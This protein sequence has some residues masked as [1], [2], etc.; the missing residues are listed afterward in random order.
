MPF[1]N[2]AFFICEMLSIVY[3][4]H[5]V[6]IV[7]YLNQWWQFYKIDFPRDRILATKRPL[8]MWYDGQQSTSHCCHLCILCCYSF[9]VVIWSRQ[10]YYWKSEFWL[11][12]ILFYHVLLGHVP[13]PKQSYQE[14]LGLNKVINT[15][16]LYFKNI[17]NIHIN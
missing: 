12:K 17:C 14:V 1:I 11:K 15:N 7:H 4:W 5:E 2:R 6:D 16:I 9:T 13:Q 10:Y 8:L 3:L